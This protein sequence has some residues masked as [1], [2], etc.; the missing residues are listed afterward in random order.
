MVVR[1]IK[2]PE[3]IA[4]CHLVAYE[5]VDWMCFSEPSLG[6]LYRLQ[7]IQTGAEES[8]NLHSS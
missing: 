2:F 6:T 8:E 7:I 4:D 3:G 5:Y 1:A